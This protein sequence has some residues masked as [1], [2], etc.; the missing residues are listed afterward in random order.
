MKQ[1]G[2]WDLDKA[3]SKK[4]DL[5]FANL[6]YEADLIDALLKCNVIMYNENGELD[7][8][9]LTNV[10]STDDVFILLEDYDFEEVFPSLEQVAL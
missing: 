1:I 2:Y 10:S 6:A 7:S 8:L 9:N 5:S 4:T 3:L